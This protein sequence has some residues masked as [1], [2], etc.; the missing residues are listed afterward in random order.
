MGHIYLGVFVKE[1]AGVPCK[2]LEGGQANNPRLIV[3]CHLQ[4]SQREA[5]L[6]TELL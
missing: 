1:N 3:S 5:T 6:K 2:G 4:K